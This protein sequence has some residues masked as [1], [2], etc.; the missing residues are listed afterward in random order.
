[1]NNTLA[2]LDILQ[3]KLEALRLRQ[4]ECIQDINSL[5]RE[6][7]YLKSDMQEA[8]EMQPEVEKQDDRPRTL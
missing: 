5:E 1:M 7:A 2:Q 6:I 3:Q 4:N 8:E